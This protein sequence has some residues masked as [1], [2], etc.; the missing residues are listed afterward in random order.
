MLFP[1][2]LQAFLQSQGCSDSGVHETGAW[3]TRM[4]QSSPRQRSLPVLKS[5]LPDHAWPLTLASAALCKTSHLTQTA[6]CSS[7]TTSSTSAT[8]ARRVAVILAATNHF[9]LLPVRE[10]HDMMPSCGNISSTLVITLS[11]LELLPAGM[12]SSF[13]SSYPGVACLP[14]PLAVQ[15][16]PCGAPASTQKLQPAHTQPQSPPLGRHHPPMHPLAV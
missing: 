15:R 12:L 3:P 7:Q 14:R 5:S 8:H 13:S 16:Q 6:I 9:G 1:V 2:Q 4:P 10:A 11:S